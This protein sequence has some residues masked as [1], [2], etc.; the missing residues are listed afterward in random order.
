M[1]KTYQ[2]KIFLKGS[3]PRIWRRI[4]VSPETPLPDFHK[5][6]QSTMGWTNYHLHQ[7]RKGDAIY[8]PKLEDDDFWGDMDKIDYST[9][10][11]SDLL[12]KEKDKI[13]YDYDFGDGW[14]HD[15]LL[16]KIIMD[17]EFDYLPVCI[18]GKNNC[19]PEDCGGI[20]GYE[21]LLET[22]NNP[23]AKNYEETIEWVGEDFDP[24]YFNKDEINDKLRSK[25]FG[26][27]DF[28]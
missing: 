8:S 22:L 24:E 19:P 9:K 7:F 21:Y 5:I 10:K 4:L 16:E 15:I 28:Y 6:I 17:Q 12:K 23:E 27:F 26:C 25:N 11:V 13:I 3:Q 1:K 20:W 2:I 18:K 14:T